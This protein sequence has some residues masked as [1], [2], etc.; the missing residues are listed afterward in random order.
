MTFSIYTVWC[1]DTLYALHAM[2]LYLSSNLKISGCK[3]YI[4][5]PNHTQPRLCAA[6][7]VY[8]FRQC[9]YFSVVCSSLKSLGLKWRCLATR[10]Y[11]LK[12]PHGTKKSWITGWRCLRWR[13]GQ[14][15][16]GDRGPAHPPPSV[17]LPSSGTDKPVCTQHCQD[18]TS[19]T[20]Q[21]IQ[22][23]WQLWQQNMNRNWQ[24]NQT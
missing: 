21:S 12:Q 15:C 1:S 3:S 17:M 2:H 19:F 5:P 8:K 6:D 7:L 24:R 10:Q 4:L 16:W 22:K 11:M 9:S 18:T 14:R 13:P 23:Q 20:D